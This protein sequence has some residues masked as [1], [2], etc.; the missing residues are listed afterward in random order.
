MILRHVQVGCVAVYLGLYYIHMVATFRMLRRRP[1]R[2]MRL[3]NLL[4]RIQ[5][6]QGC[7]AVGAGMD[8]RPC[9]GSEG[10]GL[11][12]ACPADDCLSPW[13]GV[14]SPA[15]R[16][17]PGTQVRQVATVFG[18]MALSI[19]FLLLVK[20]ESC[21][22]FIFAWFGII[23]AQV[24]G[25]RVRQQGKPRKST[26]FGLHCFTSL[27]PA[28]I[29]CNAWLW[30]QHVESPCSA[31]YEAGRL[32]L[33]LCRHAIPGCGGGHVYRDSMV[34][35]ALQPTSPQ[36]H[37][38]GAAPAAGALRCGHVACPHA[39]HPPASVTS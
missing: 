4:H 10:R 18:A 12:E 16:P 37:T 36:Q 32:R 22:T 13:R 6:G 33:S 11:R 28:V 31:P 14:T 39:S 34:L 19:I 27:V 23:P 1:Y 5:V 15:L 38:A 26:P 2:Q 29:L 3:S 30:Q 17:S 35:Y 21:W 25:W 8:D 7:S 9:S 24:G 20:L